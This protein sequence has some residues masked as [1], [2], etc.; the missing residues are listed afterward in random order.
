[1]AQPLS[2]VVMSR[3]NLLV[4]QFSHSALL[5]VV[6]QALLSKGPSPHQDAVVPGGGKQIRH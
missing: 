3:R 4:G 2:H 6:G 5:G 1:M